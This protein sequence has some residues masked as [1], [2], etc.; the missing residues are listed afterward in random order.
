VYVFTVTPSCAVTSTTTEFTPTISATGVLAL[1]ETTGVPFT[2]TLA[3]ASP[4]TGVTL[5]EAFTY[6]TLT[7]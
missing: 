5:N 3:V 2:F 6:G 1:P 7:A 4:I